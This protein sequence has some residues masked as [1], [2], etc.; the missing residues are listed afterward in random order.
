L[1]IF[2]VLR[3]GNI[4]PMG[5]DVGMQNSLEGERLT[6]SNVESIS[7]QVAFRHV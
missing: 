5:K 7:A 1:K 2:V 6:D 3:G 4:L